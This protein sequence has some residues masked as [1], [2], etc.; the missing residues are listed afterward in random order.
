MDPI[1]KGFARFNQI[2]RYS[3]T[4]NGQPVTGEGEIFKGSA[5]GITG[6]FSG[7]TE[8][9]TL[10]SSNEFAQQCFAVQAMRFALGRNEQTADA[11][12]A[13]G[14]WDKFVAGKLG[15]RPLFISLTGM[16]AFSHRNTVKA[17]MACR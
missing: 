9:A 12:S 5:S 14:V 8:L 10:I 1:G 17:G 13:K 4:D 3:E 11:C 6:K 2:G 15:V 16:P 7:V